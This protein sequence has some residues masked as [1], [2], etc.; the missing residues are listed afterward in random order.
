MKKMISGLM[1]MMI[2]FISVVPLSA[3]DGVED[4]QNKA[5]VTS[6]EF[7][8]VD[9]NVPKFVEE[10]DIENP[11]DIIEADE[12][13]D[14]DLNKIE[15]Q[16]YIV[17]DKNGDLGTLTLEPVTSNV[18]GSYNINYGTQAW[19]VYWYGPIVFQSYYVTV[20]RSGNVCNITNWNYESY[21]CVGCSNV[22]DTLTGGSKQVKYKISYTWGGL[23]SSTQTLYSEINGT[24]LKTFVH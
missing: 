1:V 20:K 9:V 21:T 4:A 14:F 10:S 18:R 19:K 3:S 5:A 24:K 7:N 17:E 15:T 12:E 23:G 2:T 6:M 22:K 11:N 13:I 8:G 16:T